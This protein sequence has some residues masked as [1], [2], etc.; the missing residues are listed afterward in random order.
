MAVGFGL[1]I[2]AI[3]ILRIW[4]HD[5]EKSLRKQMKS[6]V[7]RDKINGPWQILLSKEGI[8]VCMPMGLKD[9]YSWESLEWLVE[10]E[11]VFY[12]FHRDKRHYIMIA[13]ESFQSG[14]QVS[15]FYQLCAEKG[16]KR[17]PAKKARYIP[18]W[19]WVSLALLL[20]FACVGTFVFVAVTFFS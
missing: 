16:T 3:M 10:T 2:T 17:I 13:K 9:F 12:I 15:A 5:P 20:M 19:V 14:D 7:M 6:P 8:S 11:E 1:S 18:D 4:T